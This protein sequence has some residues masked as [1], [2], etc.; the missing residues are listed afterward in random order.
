[1]S[2]CKLGLVS[3]LEASQLMNSVDFGVAASPLSLLEKS[4]TAVCLIEHGLPLIVNR[5]VARFT[6]VNP[7]DGM[8]DQCL[9]NWKTDFVPKLLQARRRPAFLRGSAVSNKFLKS[10][11]LKAT[12]AGPLPNS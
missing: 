1:M 12:L 5:N 9:L 8:S 6:G 3:A 7:E 10:L 11:G 2:W 4:G